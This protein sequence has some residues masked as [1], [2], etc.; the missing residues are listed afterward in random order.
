MGKVLIKAQRGRCFLCWVLATLLGVLVWL[1]LSPFHLGLPPVVRAILVAPVLFLLPGY[2]LQ[3]TFSLR[4][5]W[6]GLNL[7]PIAFG[8]SLGVGALAWGCT[9]ILGDSLKTLT[10]LLVWAC[11]ALIAWN[12]VANHRRD[13]EQRSATSPADRQALWPYLLV[14]GTTLFWMFV[15]VCWGAL[16]MAETDN[17]YYLAIVRRIAQTQQLVPG[18]P[19]FPSVA[20]PQRGGPWV[21]LVALLVH[22]S[23]M[24]A[25]TIWDASPVVLIPVAILAHYLLADTLF[26]D[27][28]AAAL[29]CL[30]LLY[31][32]G[33]YTWDIPVMVVSPAGVGFILFL[34][35][36]A[37]AWRNI[38]D[39][40]RQVLL[41]A[42]LTGWALASIHLLVFA[43]LLLTLG[44]F[45]VLHFV[46]HRQWA[47]V[48]RVLAL[49]IIPSLL[50]V[51][52]VQA[53][54]GGG[55]QTTNPIYA[56]EWGLL[57]EWGGWHII[58]PSVL[59]GGSPSPWAWAF[60]LVPA[61]VVFARRQLWAIFLLSTMLFVVGTAFN[62]LFVEPMLRSRLVPPW[63]IWR[64]ALQVF[65]FQ[66][67]LG[68]LGAMTVRWLSQRIGQEWGKSKVIHVT[69]L[70][71]SIGLGF[72]PSAVPLV[73]PLLEYVS[74]SLHF[75]EHKATTFP[76]N[77]AEGGK[78]LHHDLPPGSVILA[79]ANTSYFI[80]ALTDHYV[81]SIP[82][83]HSS[84]FVSDDE[85]RRH[86][87][88][89]AL[90]P[91]TEMN[92]ILRILDDHQVDFVLLT[93]GPRVGA[94]S[95]SSDAY[96]R[97]VARFEGDPL[98]F[99]RVFSD[100]ANPAQQTTIFAYIPAGSDG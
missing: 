88:A 85:Q 55:S 67:V 16:F 56:D 26:K 86:D 29:S 12:A 80:S 41:L 4:R 63:G 40:N 5:E 44:S 17:W 81:V 34:V 39:G 69:L 42:L 79:D 10:Y 8:L 84:P 13:K 65:Q 51:P 48:R 73:K 74:R 96:A 37:L 43:G 71:G 24:N 53:W 1:L 28:L 30:F 93:F 27:R 75:L 50:A 25:A 87:T 19:Y 46:V 95:L 61:L 98:H 54:I 32:F 52:F 45:A 99:Q 49:T 2:L 64:V 60:L 38:Q 14:L 35:T 59:V 97:L 68:G 62:P 36:L 100:E 3:R 76:F 15:A 57:S 94:A 31:G 22:L 11:M 82:Y 83:G 72:L 20:D 78:F 47:H 21:A 70:V 90:D 18:D 6:R 92:E 7:L 58:R 66:F 89:R 9:R 77:W 91:N 23:G 33:R